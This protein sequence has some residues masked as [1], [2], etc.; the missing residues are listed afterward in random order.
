MPLELLERNRFRVLQRLYAL[1]SGDTERRLGL[2]V[3]SVAAALTIPE[4][5]VTQAVA[6]LVHAHYLSEEEATGELC[7]TRRA[8][9]Y[10]EAGA[11]QRQTI[12]D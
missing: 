10:L 6:F 3:P 8:V 7:I 4:A 2:D 11:Y 5:D 12:R 1:A 9:Y